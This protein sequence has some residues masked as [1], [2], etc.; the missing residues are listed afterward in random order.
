M[1]AIIAAAVLPHR[2]L[3][4]AKPHSQI[5]PQRG[6][7]MKKLYL[8]CYSGISGDMTAGALLDLGA[9]EKKLLAAL[10]TVP[11]KGFSVK[12]STVQKSG[13]NACDFA[14]SLEEE[15]HDHDMA[16]LYGDEAAQ[17]GEHPHTDEEHVHDHGEN[18]DHGHGHRH[19]HRN[20]EEV[21]AILD[22][23]KMTEDARNLAKKIFL[24]VAEAESRV[25]GKPLNEVHFHEVGALD[26]IADIIAIAVCFDDLREREN[27]E[28][29]IVP[30]LYEGTGTIRCQ[31]GVLPVPVPAV[32]AIAEQYHLP[33]HIIPD[34]GEFVTPTGAA[35]AAVLRT[36]EALP[37]AFRIVRTGLGAGK[38]AYKRAGV[39]RAMILEV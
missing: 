18:P 27:L 20:L 12:I 36:E 13:I 21:N 4:S 37:E 3:H 7:K 29:V 1:Q 24:A 31:H 10:A 5:L 16:W 17:E 28:G 19:T 26:S 11:A 34:R 23:T 14:V 6:I 22:A 35:A 38:R 39:L 8:E 33:L 30:V 25:H 9:D 2:L 32:T 15:N